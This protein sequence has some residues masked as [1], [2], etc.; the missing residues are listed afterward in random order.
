MKKIL[1]LTSVTLFI[2]TACSSNIATPI[3]TALPSTETLITTFTSTPQPTKI[4]ILMPTPGIGSTMISDKDNM[5]L[6]YV[7][8]GKFTMGDI[9]EDALA[10]CQNYHSDCQLSWFKDEEP[11]HDVDLSAFWIDQ[12]EV[13]NKQYATCVDAGM[14]EPPSDIR[15][16]TR[17]KYYRN[18]DFDNYPVIFLDWHQAK[19]YCS[20]AGRE[21]PSE[22]QWE[23]AA[24]GTDAHIYPWGNDAPNKD[25][26]NYNS[27]VG[28]TTSVGNYETGK[29][30]YGAYDMAG[31]VLEW[32]ND[33]YGESYYQ[34]SPSSNPLGPDSG[35]YRVLRGG[36]WLDYNYF[37][38]SPFRYRL[39]PS[40]TH[41]FLG[42]RCA[43]SQ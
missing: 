30:I 33:W 26:L 13:T 5:T 15:S 12:T 37:V 24:R 18:P 9:A 25:L 3:A 19:A 4:S 6:L 20:W 22:A 28:D 36:A 21:L 16:Y 14:C 8:A 11:R 2:L 29:S 32:V 35:R 27:N 41:R 31:N 34:G 40:L 43:R 38:R 23:K 7:P 42:F 39:D 17:P 10:E 1:Y